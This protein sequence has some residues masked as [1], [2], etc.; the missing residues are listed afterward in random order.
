[1]SLA[2]VISAGE[3]GSLL[4]EVFDPASHTTFSWAHT[5]KFH[6][7]Q[8]D[9]F[10]FNVPKEAGTSILYRDTDKEIQVSYSGEIFVD[11]TTAQVLEIDS[12]FD[13]PPMFPIHVAQRKVEYA[14][15]QIA[16]KSYSLPARS[17]VHM[18]DG[19][20]SYDN[21]IDFKDYHRFTS[22]STLHFDDGGQP[23]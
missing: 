10:R 20:H 11:P 2:G 16:G 12:K 5:E 8:V 4:S 7:R 18:E 15:Q 14:P 21:R 9:V 1:M 23:K 19:I 17:L 22:E 3:F 13:L 6:G